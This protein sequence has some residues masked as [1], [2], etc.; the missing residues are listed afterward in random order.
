M[1]NSLRANADIIV[2]L[3][4]DIAPETT[5]GYEP[6][7]HPH[8]L[9]GEEEEIQRSISCCETSIHAGLAEFTAA[10]EGYYRRGKA[11]APRSPIRAENNGVLSEHAG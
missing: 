8:K 11:S 4:K 1:V 7:I 9:E 5:E 6:Y 2:R 10:A 3:P